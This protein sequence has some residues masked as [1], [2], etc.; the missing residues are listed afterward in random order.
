[1]KRYTGSF[2]VL[3]LLIKKLQQRC[4]TFRTAGIQYI[5]NKNKTSCTSL[6]IMFN[7]TETRRCF[8]VMV[9]S[10]FSRINF[11]LLQSSLLKTS[12]AVGCGLAIILLEYLLIRWSQHFL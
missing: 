7:Q 3:H 10:F 9:Q 12:I 1:M 4:K 11:G 6:I 8:E 2:L 5:N